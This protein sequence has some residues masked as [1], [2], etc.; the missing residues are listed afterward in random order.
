MSSVAEAVG[1]GIEDE[2]ALD[3]GDRVSHQDPP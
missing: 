1:Q 3:I 2:V